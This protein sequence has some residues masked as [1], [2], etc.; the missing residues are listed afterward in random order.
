MTVPHF[1]GDPAVLVQ[2]DRIDREELRE[3]L[4]DARLLRAPRRLADD[5]VGEGA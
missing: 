1:H 4:E 5:F 3:R 2:L